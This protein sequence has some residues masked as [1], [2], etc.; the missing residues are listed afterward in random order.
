MVVLCST[1]WRVALLFVLSPRSSPLLQEQE[2]TMQQ[3]TNAIGG[4]WANGWTIVSFWT[5]LLQ[6]TFGENVGRHVR[7][8]GLR[9]D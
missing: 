2:G 4:R 9:S 1:S 3:R 6:Q 5:R 7:A 8:Q